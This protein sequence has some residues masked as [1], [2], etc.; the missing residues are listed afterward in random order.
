MKL[1]IIGYGKMGKEVEKI[2]VSRGHEVIFKLNRLQFESLSKEDFLKVDVAIEFTNPDSVIA[3]L[4]KCFNAQVPVVT[5]STGWYD[6]FENVKNKCLQNNSALFYASN[7]SIGVN[8]FFKLNEHL[9]AL[10]KPHTDYKV[11][12]EEA[13]HIHKKDAPSGTA[14]TLAKGIISNRDDL[15]NYSIEETNDESIIPIKIIREGEIP[16]THTINYHSLTDE[17]EI[18]HKAFNRS[19]FAFGAVMAAEFLIGKRGVFSMKDLLND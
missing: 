11:S 12:M 17:I 9:A 15:K 19:G 5:G 10:M 13:H 8:I 16:G 6:Q 7:F 18:T 3:N 14:I 1:A 2:A 4:E